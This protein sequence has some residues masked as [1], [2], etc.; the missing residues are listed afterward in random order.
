M[1]A[2]AEAIFKKW[3]LDFAVIGITT[4]TKRLV[5]KHRGEVVEWMKVPTPIR[6]LSCFP[7][8]DLFANSTQ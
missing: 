2:E 3:E 4:D 7:Q 1:E 6:H 5:V 8:V